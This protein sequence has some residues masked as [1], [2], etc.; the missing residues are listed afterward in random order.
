[1]FIIAFLVISISIARLRAEF[2]APFHDVEYN[3]PD[4]VMP[5]VLGSALLGPRALGMLSMQFWY[6]AENFTHPMPH[7]IEALRIGSSPRTGTRQTPFFWGVLL[8]W[9]VG[10]SLC[11]VTV[12]YFGQQ[13]GYM[14]SKT[15]GQRTEWYGGADFARLDQILA[16]PTGSRPQS[17]IAIMVGMLTCFGLQAMRLRMPGWPLDPVAYSLASTAT[18]SSYWLP[19]FLA[20]VAK[21]LILRYGG[22]RGYTQALPFFLG[23]V[24]GEAF[25]GVGWSLVGSILHQQ[26]YRYYYF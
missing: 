11:I 18:A 26:T 24:I 19:L 22:R 20:W 10:M 17:M 3:T 4:I 5:K 8:A 12:L 6:T 13:L 14:T 21:S 1:V 25:V 23:L 9:V 15:L 7:S 16:T 2:G